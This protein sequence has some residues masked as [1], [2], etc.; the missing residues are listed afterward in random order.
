MYIELS[1]ISRVECWFFQNIGNLVVPFS[2]KKTIIIFAETL[3]DLQHSTRLVSES[4]SY[5]CLIMF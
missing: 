5:M 2:L 4:R 3:E 1:E